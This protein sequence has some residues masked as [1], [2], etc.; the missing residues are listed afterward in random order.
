MSKNKIKEEFSK[1]IRIETI[2]KIFFNC[3]AVFLVM[4]FLAA[5]TGPGI[6]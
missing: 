4:V 1:E 2:A 5:A 3:T 6:L